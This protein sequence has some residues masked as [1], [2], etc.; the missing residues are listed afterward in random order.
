MMTIEYL[1]NK[2]PSALRRRTELLKTSATTNLAYLSAWWWQVS[3]GNKCHFNGMPIFNKTY[4]SKITIGNYCRFNSAMASNLIGIN[5]ACMISTLREQAEIV[6]GD[7][8]GFSGTV[9]GCAEKIEIGKNLLCGAN[10]TI[11]DFDWHNTDPSQRHGHICNKSKPI[12]IEDN[13]WLGLNVIVLK[14]VTIGTNSVIAAGS[15]VTSDIPANVIAAGQP[16]KPI[17]ILNSSFL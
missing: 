5:R 7:G 9:I 3:L 13:V 12:I 14:G 6:I 2:L 16:A 11:T 17:K 4:D 8:C 15:I 10:T 1:R